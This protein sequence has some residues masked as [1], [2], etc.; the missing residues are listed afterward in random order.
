VLEFAGGVGLGVDVGDFLEL[1]RAFHGDRV[2]VAAAEEERVLLVGETLAQALISGSSS[3]TFCTATGRWRSAVRWR[4]S[5][6]VEAAV[7][8]GERQRQQR[9]KAASWVVKAL[10]EATPIS[11]PARVMKRSA[12]SRTM[13]DSGTLQMA[14]VRPCRAPWRA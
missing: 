7:E 14:S 2:V 10:V 3:S 8:L 5:F 6:G 9:D 12:H 11:G 13:A 4:S 1:E